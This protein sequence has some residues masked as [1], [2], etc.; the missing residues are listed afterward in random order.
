MQFQ[1]T[2][3]PPLSVMSHIKFFTFQKAGRVAMWTGPL[4]HGFVSFGRNL[5]SCSCPQHSFTTFCWKTGG[6]GTTWLPH[7][8]KP[9]IFHFEFAFYA[10]VLNH[11]LKTSFSSDILFNSLMS[12][13]TSN[14]CEWNRSKRC[15]VDSSPFPTVMRTGTSKTLTSN[16]VISCLWCILKLLWGF[17]ANAL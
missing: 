14:I 9:G 4:S 15:R 16:A 6:S 13:L 7:S 17:S 3:S 11:L 10:L 1:I 2:S 8:L 12:P 5:K